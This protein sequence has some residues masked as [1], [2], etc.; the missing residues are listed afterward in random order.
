M[1]WII[2]AD[3]GLFPFLEQNAAHALAKNANFGGQFFPIV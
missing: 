2:G 3:A 1:G